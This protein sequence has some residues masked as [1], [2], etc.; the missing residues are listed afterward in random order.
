[1]RSRFTLRR[2]RSVHVSI[3]AITLAVPA[4]ALAFSGATTNSGQSA[5][6]SIQT[7]LALHVSPRR[8][9]YGK[10]ITVRGIAPAGDAGTRVVVQTA[11]ASEA[12]WRSLGTATV[13]PSGTF[14][15]R[16]VPRHSGL[17]RA[18]ARDAS[19][20]APVAVAA[21]ATGAS[22]PSPQPAVTVGARFTPA[23]HASA[24]LSTE[25]VRVHGKLLP[26][27]PG[28][29]VRLEAHTAHGWHTLTSAHT[30]ARGGYRLTL[31][32]NAADGRRLRMVFG[33]DRRNS[34][35]MRAAGSITMLHPA[36]ASWYDDGGTTACGF[37]AGLGV[38]NRTLPCGTKVTFRY[39]GRSV[40]AVVD[41]RGP[42]AGGREWDLNQNTASA[43]GFGGV[44][45][46]WSSE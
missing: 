32:P 34:R 16:L 44:G 8:V 18:V 37:H 1:M 23:R 14:R 19:S 5:Q 36:L 24:V 45:T 25:P 6:N 15:T 41:D 35:A 4:S 10:A 43:L 7:P 26:G 17:L 27:L 39:G 38:A 29:R 9:R 31:S 20:G 3:A 46:V 22:A 13:T 28:R 33:G 42:Y 21:A 40:T 11:T 2:M 12:P 30:G